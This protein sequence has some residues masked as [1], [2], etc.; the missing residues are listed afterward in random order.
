MHY[1]CL[2][3]LPRREGDAILQ[4]MERAAAETVKSAAAQIV[5][6]RGA[7]GEALSIMPWRTP[8]SNG[9]RLPGKHRWRAFHWRR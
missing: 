6:R 5:F 9:P 3:Q 8:R 7:F 4:E 1:Y 2:F